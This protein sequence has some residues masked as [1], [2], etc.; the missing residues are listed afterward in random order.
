VALAEDRA[1]LAE[2]LDASNARAT[3]LGNVNREVSRRL[4]QAIDTIRS[5][6]AAHER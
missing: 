4:D 1:H 3:T 6:L 2:E 5:V